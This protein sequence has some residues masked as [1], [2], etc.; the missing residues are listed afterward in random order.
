MKIIRTSAALLVLAAASA[1]AQTP[2]ITVVENNYGNIVPGLPNYGIAQGSI[3]YIKGTNLAPGT[4][5]LQNVPLKQT[6][7]GVTINIKGSDGSTKPAYIYY[8]SPTQIDGILPSAVPVGAATITVSN[9]GAFSAAVPIQ[10]VQSAFGLLTLNG[11]GTGMIAAFDANNNNALLSVTAAANPGDVLVLWGSGL[12]PVT[13]DESLAQT[14]TDFSTTMEV[15]IGGIPVVSTDKANFFYHGRSAYPGLDQ[16]NVK[17]P[18]GVTP[19]CAV[20]V[21]VKTGNYVSNFG[22]MPIAASGRTCSDSALGLSTTQLQ[23]IINKGTYSGG[24]ISLTK[25]SSAGISIPGFPSTGDTVTESGFGD[26]V[27]VTVP[28]TFDISALLQS[29]SFGSCTI[30]GSTGSTFTV[31][32][33][34]TTALNAG[35][36]I[37]VTGP[38]GTQSLTLSNG[39]YSIDK[40]PS[41]FITAGTYTIDNGGGG[42]DVGAFSGKLVVPTPMVWSNKDAITTVTRSN[43]L[44]ITWT[45]GDP[46]TYVEITGTSFGV[47]P[48]NASNNVFGYFVCTA[49]ASAHTYTVP[50]TVLLTLPPST[51]IAGFSTSMLAV[52]NAT[53]AQAFTPS[54]PT[55]DYGFM[56]A[57]FD[58]S[59]FV[60]FQ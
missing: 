30:Y 8:L 37:N 58:T 57:S 10:V 32:Q 29:V 9:N 34:T 23:S 45:G 13:G 27:K 36:K 52:S 31:P 26:F 50:S 16:I 51:S 20:S 14:Q 3:F 43:G 49:P 17:V 56:F 25:T 2:A 6:L 15:D 18:A 4:T 33:V 40:F 55:I 19:G 46:S 41:G 7:N 1:W 60:T 59:K 48:T 54:S 11:G 44:Q 35:P 24:T 38:A 39:F 12:G 53:N 28:Q 21:A 22:T 5:T 47:D 42:P